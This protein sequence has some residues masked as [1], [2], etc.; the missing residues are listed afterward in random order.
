M[1]LSPLHKQRHRARSRLSGH[2]SLTPMGLNL[3]LVFRDI[4]YQGTII[5]TIPEF[6]L[7]RQH[8]SA[9]RDEQDLSMM[10]GD[11]VFLI[12]DPTVDPQRQEDYGAMCSMG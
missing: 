5:P 9:A 8:A 1:H 7:V 6:G 4:R 3:P 12:D 11:D 10:R 2:E